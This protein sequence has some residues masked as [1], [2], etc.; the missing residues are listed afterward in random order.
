MNLA[1]SNRRETA[2]PLVYGHTGGRGISRKWTQMDA[3]LMT[4]S[5]PSG[6]A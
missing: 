2:A 1:R 5:R 4:N 6:M 3:N